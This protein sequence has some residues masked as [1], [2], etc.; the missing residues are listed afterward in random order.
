M[1]ADTIELA[2][3]YFLGGLFEC[4]FAFAF[5]VDTATNTII[6]TSIGLKEELEIEY[7]KMK[8]VKIL[9]PLE[10]DK[11]KNWIADSKSKFGKNLDN[12]YYGISYES[13]QLILNN[14]LIVG[15]YPELNQILTLRRLGVNVFCCL[16]DEYGKYVKGRIYNPYKGQLLDKELF[17]HEPILDMQTIS[18]NKIDDLSD[19]LVALILAGKKVYLHCGGGHGR[20]GMVACA[21]LH[22]LYPDLSE[23]EIMDYVQFAHDQRTGSF[24]R[25]KYNRDIKDTTLAAC[26]V[27]GQVPSPQTSDQRELVSRVIQNNKKRIDA[28]KNYDAD[29]YLQ[30]QTRFDDWFEQMKQYDM[31]EQLLSENLVCGDLVTTSQEKE[32]DEEF[33]FTFSICGKTGGR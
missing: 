5:I 26:F 29:V 24:D 19:K 21:T 28:K 16:N 27:D 33:V 9:P 1:S 18:D 25:I 31:Q 20:A 3:N 6:K 17:I 14:I 23:T 10:L 11:S 12:K 15:A 30:Q 32:Q 13:N 8:G 4:G 22:K 7:K 2:T